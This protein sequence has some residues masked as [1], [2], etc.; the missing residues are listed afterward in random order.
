MTP[1]RRIETR[2]KRNKTSS[3]Q[4]QQRTIFDEVQSFAIFAFVAAISYF[5]ASGRYIS[6]VT[7]RSVPYLVFAAIVLFV[8]AIAAWLGVFHCTA[9]SLSKTLIVIILPAL[10]LSVPLDSASASTISSTN[11]AIAIHATTDK[12]LAGLD[13]TKKIITIHDD[14]FGAWFD[15]IDQH[16]EQYLGYTVIV[17]GFVSK[18]SSLGSHQFSVSRMLMTCCVLDMTPFGFVVNTSSSSTVPSENTWVSV[19]GTIE[20][21]HIGDA[22]HGYD[23]IV[24]QAQSVRASTETPNGYFYR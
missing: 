1:L 15:R 23:G 21:G 9:A 2:F 12:Q 14:D 18:D 17:E 6:F 16:V 22:H 24:L 10:L 3:D 4:H 20:R 8:F 11:R 19:R 13:T 5:V 7:P